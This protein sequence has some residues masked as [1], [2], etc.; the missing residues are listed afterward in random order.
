MGEEIT[1]SRVREKPPPPVT[2]STIFTEVASVN[3]IKKQVA[4]Q[5]L[6]DLTYQEDVLLVS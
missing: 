4:F 5:V 2:L 3:V 6:Q 1:G